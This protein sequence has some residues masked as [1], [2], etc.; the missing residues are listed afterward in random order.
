MAKLVNLGRFRKQ[1][2]REA[3]RAKAGATAVKHG[4]G[5]QAREAE[6]RALERARD[7]LEQHRLERDD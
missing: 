6:A 7:L 1:K 4:R 2:A 5:K 3:R